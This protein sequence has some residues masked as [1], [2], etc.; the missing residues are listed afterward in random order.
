MYPVTP[1]LSV[2]AF[3]LR[4][5]SGVLVGVALRPAGTVG[6]VES[7]V[8]VLNGRD[9]A[10]WLPA[11]SNASTVYVPVT[12]TGPL[13]WPV[14]VNYTFS[15]ITGNAG[16][17]YD[18]TP[19]SVVIPT[20]QVSVAI[21]VRVYGHSSQAGTNVFGVHITSPTAPVM[22]GSAYVS[23]GQAVKKH[24]KPQVQIS[25]QNVWEGDTGTNFAH[26]TV[27]LDRSSI[28]PVVVNYLTADGTALTGTDY[29]GSSAS[30]TIPVGQTSIDLTIPILTDTFPEFTKIFS[31]QLTSV[32]GT[33]A[34]LG[35]HTT[36]KVAILDD[37]P[38][39]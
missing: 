28:T 10:E 34:V 3:Q 25:D 36:G 35:P 31:V 2:E 16:I 21:P 9:C 13:A 24:T 29:T 4:S 18:G 12:L 1:T 15:D 37:D 26:V 19:G 7:G 17:D 32:V 27:S 33:N 8:F 20:G 22:V 5:T 14:T 39:P 23:F 30:V 38:T 6:G 11:A